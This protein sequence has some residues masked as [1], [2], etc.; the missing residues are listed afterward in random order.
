MPLLSINISENNHERLRYMADQRRTTM[1]QI[2][3]DLVNKE[4][5][6][7]KS[8]YLIPCASCR[9]ASTIREL[10]KSD[11]LCPKCGKKVRMLRA[12]K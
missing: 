3:I 2:V 12:P 8:E 5:S 6:D 11:Y 7:F 9:T 4:Y 10:E 1:T